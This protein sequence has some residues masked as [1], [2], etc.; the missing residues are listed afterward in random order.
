MRQP[1]SLTVMASIQQEVRTMTIEQALEEGL[2]LEISDSCDC[3]IDDDYEIGV[4]FH[5][6]ECY[7][8]DMDNE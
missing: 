2:H 6:A 5:Q 7:R 1:L 4:G 8:L 3:N